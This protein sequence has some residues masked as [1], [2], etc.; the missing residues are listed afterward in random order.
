LMTEI[1]QQKRLWDH[2]SRVLSGR[3]RTGGPCPGCAWIGWAGC[4]RG[5]LGAAGALLAK[6][7]C[8][9]GGVLVPAG[10]SRWV[11]QQLTHTP[12]LGWAGPAWP[13]ADVRPAGAGGPPDLAVPRQLLPAAGAQPLQGLRLGIYKQ[14]FEHASADIVAVCY[15]AVDQLKAL[16]ASV[17]VG[18]STCPPPPHP[19]RGPPLLII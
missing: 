5:L 15:S 4:V 14:W 3:A 2:R 7:T 17:Q 8:S 12:G 16:G 9:R 1:T 18:A 10:A 11:S 6:Q 13:T 19:L